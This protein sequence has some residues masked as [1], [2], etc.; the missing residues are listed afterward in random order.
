M[1]VLVL[2]HSLIRRDPRLI[3]QIEWLRDLGFHE[4]TTLGIGSRPDFVSNH[5]AIPT[6]S[7]FLRAIG[8]LIPNNAFRF[9][10]FYGRFIDS[11]WASINSRYDLLVINGIEYLHW[12]MFR[13]SPLQSTPLYLDIHE[14]HVMP[15]YRG[16]LE[17]LAFGRYWTWQLNEMLAMVKSHKATV[18]ISS[19][20]NRLA[21][22]YEELTGKSVEII[23]NAPKTNEF[24]VSQVQS[25]QIKLVHHGMGTK[26]RG[27]EQI[28]FALRKVRHAFTLDL[29]L[30][31][32]PLFNLKIRLL[33]GI[34]GLGKRVKIQKGVP[35]SE[36]PKTL[37]KYD[38]SL[39][40][41][42]SKTPGHLNSLPNKFFE[43]MHS[44]LAVISGPNPTMA[45]I[46]I[47][48]G[49]G[50]VLPDWSSKQLALCLNQL[51]P[52]VIMMYK[53]RSK[54]VSKKYSEMQSS[55]VF[56]ELI[57]NIVTL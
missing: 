39:I 16:I 44:G 6:L 28:L 22:A 53:K 11:H 52:D 32:T 33:V 51:N 54:E 2:S 38:I 55:K 1:R 48:E 12:K 35:L 27:I 50:Q 17:R 31:S 10:F 30:F 19:V 45:Q 13:S 9:Q 29:I 40:L 36:L 4:I 37:S 49:I 8:Y 56:F 20:E 34:L 18:K 24:E 26:G 3:R 14:D 43:S 25:K 7:I 23:M 5:F 57:R 15:A 47:E 46:I 42:S 21:G 41:L